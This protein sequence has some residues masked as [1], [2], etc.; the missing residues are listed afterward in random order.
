MP[1]YKRLVKRGE[2]WRYMGSF[3]GVKY[4]SKAIYTTRK[5]CLDVERE[6][7]SQLQEEAQKPRKKVMLYD[8]LNARLDYAQTRSKFYYQEHKRYLKMLFDAVGN[9]SVHEVE[10]KQ[11]ADVIAAF[12]AR[13]KKNGKTQHKANSML[14]IFKATFFY[15]IDLY[16]L[17]IRNPVV[18]IKFSPIDK[19]LKYIPRDNDIQAVTA[20]CNDRQRLLIEFVKETGCRIQE[21]L[22]LTRNDILDT[23]VVLYTRKAKNANL[24]PRKLDKP[25]CIA[26]LR[27][28]GRLFKE[29]NSYPRF[30]EDKVKELKQKSWNWHNLRHRFASQLSKNGTPLFE[31]MLKLGHSNLS[32]TQGYL[33][34]LP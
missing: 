20:I 14:R 7:L 8:F 16:E 23:E 33:Q 32:T 13:L 4:S 22:R 2:R 19:R 34:L 12:S 24:T 3:N 26:D 27:F 25:A 17:E 30:L 18:G 28:T 5:A 9:I 21:A 15:G 1:A 10:K 29:W 31:I 11:V 6:Y